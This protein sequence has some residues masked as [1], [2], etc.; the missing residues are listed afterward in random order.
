MR[1]QTALTKNRGKRRE[2][3][4]NG[5][6]LRTDDNKVDLDADWEFRDQMLDLC[7]DMGVK[8][9]QLRSDDFRCYAKTISI[10]V[11][12][13]STADRLKD[14]AH[15]AAHVG[16]RHSLLRMTRQRMEFETG[17][18]EVQFLRHC[19]VP[20]T[21]NQSNQ[22]KKYVA[23]I[24]RMAI[25]RGVR[26]FDRQAWKYAR[27]IRHESWIEQDL[28]S[29]TPQLVDQGRDNGFDEAMSRYS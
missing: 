8:I 26:R 27:S 23:D 4:V 7:S 5:V 16:F 9:V 3:I 11:R 29:I 15:E 25:R 10:F 22:G 24:L 14:V 13:P 1:G 28:N 18:F 21:K 12:P 17:R 19:G 20:V 2:L 6:T